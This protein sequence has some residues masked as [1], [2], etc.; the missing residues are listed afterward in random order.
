MWENASLQ[1]LLLSLLASS[2]TWKPA[3]FIAT[4]KNPKI[5]RK[6]IDIDKRMEGITPIPF[7]KQIPSEDR[8]FSVDN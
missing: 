4:K 8:G 7:N 1:S 5:E 3:D 2:H 6:L